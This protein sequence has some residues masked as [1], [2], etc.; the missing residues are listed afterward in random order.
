MSA[1][2]A[3]DAVATP[4]DDPIHLIAAGSW[5]PGASASCY[6]LPVGPVAPPTNLLF[7]GFAHTPASWREVV[8]ALPPDRIANVHV[9]P[10]PGHH[11]E[12]P[13]DVDWTTTLD[14]LASRIPT[15]AIAVGYSFGARI[16][17]GLLARDAVAAAVLIGVHPGIG[18]ATE[19]AERRATDAQ[20]S[21]LL[22]S[23][24]TSGFLDEWQRQPLFASQ[25]HANRDTLAYRR[26][27]RETLDPDQLAQ[28]LDSLGLGAMPDLTD[29]LVA[30]ADRA[31]LIV[32]GND[33]RFRTI[34]AQL[35]RRA[36]IPVVTIDGAG[37][38]PTLDAPDRLAGAI[39]GALD[40]LAAATR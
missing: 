1:V 11:P 19:R 16:A 22:R 32:G 26:R 13:V 18:A 14:T 7:H 25:A 34:A 24:G 28:S 33:P 3:R 23:R 39:A 9:H 6:T 15:A 30:R 29:A 38:D 17:L 4:T 35:H 37:H 31:R 36:G 40:E 2:A 20:W 10:T 5:R 21:Q 27:T 12:Y 8:A